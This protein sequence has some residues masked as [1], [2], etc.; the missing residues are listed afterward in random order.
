MYI[1][2]QC[3]DMHSSQNIRKF[4]HTPPSPQKKKKEK[5]NKNKKIH[6][7]DVILNNIVSQLCTVEQQQKNRSSLK[8][9][10]IPL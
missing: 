7:F 3:L 8:T 10:M 1:Q 6:V 2:N 4:P 9:T 5:Q